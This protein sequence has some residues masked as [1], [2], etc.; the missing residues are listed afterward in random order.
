MPISAGDRLGPHEIVALIGAGGMGEVYRAKDTKLDRLVAIKI[1][2]DALAQDPDRLARFEREAKVLAALNHPNIATIYGVEEH[3]LVMELVEGD[4]LRTPLPIETALNYARQI[5]DALEAAHDKGIIHRDLKPANVKVTPEGVVKVLDFGLAAVTEKSLAAPDDPAN[6]PTL[7]IRATRAGMI[8]GTAAYMSPEQAAGKAVDR[9]ADIW[10]FGVVLWELLTGRRLFAGET[11]S[12][13]LADVLRAEIDFSKLPSATPAPIREVLKRCLDR[14]VKTRLR[15]IGEA[16]VAIQRWLANPVEEPV[17]GPES[18]RQRKIGVARG[19][20]GVA[21]LFAAVLASVHFR[22]TL[23]ETPVIRT[24]ILPPETATF[25]FT[26]GLG[27][28]ALSP[29]GKRIAFEARTTDGKNP[30]WVRPMDGLSGQPLAGTNG[31]TFAF[32]S[33]DSRSIAFFADGKLKK[34]DASGG[35]ALTLADAPLGRGGS[36]SQD[37]V[38]IFSPSNRSGPLLRIS[39]A[40]GAVSPVSSDQGRFPWFLP[41][42]QHFLFQSGTADRNNGRIL[43]GSLDG[44]AAK[45]VR[46]GAS[47]NAIYGQGRLLFLQ[48]GTLM[49]QPFDTKRLAT[50]GEAVPIAEQVQSLLSSGTVEAVSVSQSGLL[51]YH[52]RGSSIGSAL[53]WFDQSGK[54]GAT[55]GIPTI[56]DSFQLSPDGKSLAAT[57][58]D[59]GG[60]GNAD[61]WTY[62]VSRGLPTRFTFD[63][64]PDVDPIWSPDGRTIVFR[65]RRKEHFDL[66]RKSADGAGNEELLYSDDL[67][68]MP[69]SWSPDGKY[70]LYTAFGNLKTAYDIWVLPLTPE[71]PGTPLKPHPVL[72]T[73]FEERSGQ[74]SPDGKWIAYSSDDSQRSEVYVTPFPP[75]ASGQGGRR[76]ISTGGGVL[77]RWE[78]DGKEI[79]YSTFDRRLMAAEVTVRGASMEV[80]PVRALFGPIETAGDFLIYDVSVDG[81]RFL[82]AVASGKKAAEPLTLIQNWAARLRK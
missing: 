3:A 19:I 82:I 10:S 7:T 24:T 34:I 81:Q 51:A 61:I 15:D 44:K 73:A 70:L 67:E 18:A 30:L 60:G 54:P 8:M 22:E 45:S 16:R 40:G 80:G 75:P 74:F 12:H 26:N 32:W 65:S 79:F 52:T 23:P 33:P 47:S 38:I 25:D 36:W 69:T 9:R 76:Q 13:T 28:P 57:L 27:L 58:I 1:L 72:H 2:P 20:A 29:D 56:F 53:T 21:V 42:G 66:Y 6:S 50:T 14:D 5:A 64:A 35:P 62:D 39:S 31:A 41:D 37:G 77:P 49:A 59:V 78:A 46:D 55:V 4:N 63:A 71:H 48:N 43:V 68:K 17:G 11:V